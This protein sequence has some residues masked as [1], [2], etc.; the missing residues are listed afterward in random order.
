M[1]TEQTDVKFPIMPGG[2]DRCGAACSIGCYGIHS[3]LLSA[4][5]VLPT[6]SCRSCNRLRTIISA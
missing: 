3:F 5:I 1:D 4:L 6:E 2:D